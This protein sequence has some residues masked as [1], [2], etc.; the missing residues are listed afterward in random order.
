M[1][2]FI[3]LHTQFRPLE[4]VLSAFD[5]DHVAVEARVEHIVLAF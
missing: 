4:T 2:V 5:Y 1:F 3:P